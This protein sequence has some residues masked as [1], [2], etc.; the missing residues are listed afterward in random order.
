MVKDAVER[1]ARSQRVW[2]DSA[3]LQRRHRDAMT[4]LGEIVHGLAA[5]GELGDLEEFPEIARQLAVLEDLEERIAEAATRAREATERA[6]DA[7]ERF[8][9]RA[10]WPA[11]EG[12][13]RAWE[14]GAAVRGGRRGAS[15]GPADMAMDD[16]DDPFD[17]DP[18]D[19]EPPR[20]PSARVGADAR[21]HAAK[22]PRSRPRRTGGIEFVDDEPD[23]GDTP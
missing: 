22:K 10:A 1:Q 18:F 21:R 14:A 8:V 12:V 20:R 15:T 13:R 2:L 16:D 19:D 5:S 17:V 6:R 11:T 3:L 4:R 23:D 7:A 9:E